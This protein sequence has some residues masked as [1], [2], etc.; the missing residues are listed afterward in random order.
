MNT[1]AHAILNALVLGRG[2]WRR[3]WLPITAGALL[4]D[5]PMLLFYLHQ[6]VV[7]AVPERVIW[8]ERYFEPA[9][10]AFFDVF[11]GLPLLALGALLAWLA[12]A[13]AWLALFA[14][15]GLHALCDLALH[16]D[17][18]HRHLF[19]LSDWRLASPVSYWDPA[20]HGD[21]FL[22]AEAGLVALGGLVLLRRRDPPAWRPLG[23]V[24][25]ATYVAFL[26]F[27]WW[28]WSA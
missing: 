4:P 2:T 5:L 1:P 18:A 21:L 28:T 23:G 26:G 8:S 20:H 14:S 12:R 7:L 15:M 16:H 17:D 22:A 10:Q 3:E 11:N 19:P 25:L 27:A 13:R 24:L 9:W 6:R